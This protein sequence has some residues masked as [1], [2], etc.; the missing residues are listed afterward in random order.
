MW[1]AGDALSRGQA[2][3]RARERVVVTP[4][5][6]SEAFL[7][8]AVA[9]PGRRAGFLLFA[10]TLEAR[11]GLDV[12]ES[13]LELLER[14]GERP[15]VVLAGA[16]GWGTE[17]S[18]DRLLA[19]PGVQLEPGPS[20][21]SLSD[22]YRQ[23]LALVHPSRMEGFGLPVAEAMAAGCPV[24]ASDLDCV[25][26]FAGNAPLYSP[27]GDAEA[28]ADRSTGLR[29]SRPARHGERGVK[30]A[31]PLRWEHTAELSACAIESVLG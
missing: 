10:G 5:G 6:V 2:A 28:L 1:L 30:A 19:R 18:V 20:D 29:G 4:Y 16:S 27:P 17:E 12:L 26:E 22:L 21:A 23:A 31:R 25:R 13:A 8:P 9:E 7:G 3:R 14:A 15:E 24:V 11:K